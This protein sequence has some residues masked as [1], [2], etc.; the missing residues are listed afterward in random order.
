MTFIFGFPSDEDDAVTTGVLSV[1]NMQLRTNS[2]ISVCY[3]FLRRRRGHLPRLSEKAHELTSH[4][5][6]VQVPH[7][8]LC[9]FLT[10]VHQ[11]KQ[12]AA[13]T[14]FLF[15]CQA[16]GSILEGRTMEE[17]SKKISPA[18]RTKTAMRAAKLAWLAVSPYCSDPLSLSVLFRHCLISC[19]DTA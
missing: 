5:D 4:K 19:S 17:A 15:V 2:H 12:I 16:K 1:I 10:V 3:K 13:L 8:L 7:G 11:I 18:S 6:L 14:I 9:K